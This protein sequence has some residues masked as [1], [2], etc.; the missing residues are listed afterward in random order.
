MTRVWRHTKI[1]EQITTR[2]HVASEE[3]RTVLVNAPALRATRAVT[4]LTVHRALQ[5]DGLA[6]VQSSFSQNPTIRFEPDLDSRIDRF[7]SYPMV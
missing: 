2:D 6:G 7:K 4:R 1:H 3:F 5:V